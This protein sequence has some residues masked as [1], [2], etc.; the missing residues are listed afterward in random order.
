MKPQH[1]FHSP[2]VQVPVAVLH[3]L[4]FKLVCALYRVQVPLAVLDTF[5]FNHLRIRDILSEYAASRARSLFCVQVP[6]VVLD[7]FARTFAEGFV[8]L[9]GRLHLEAEV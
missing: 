5:K 1:P 6:V 4:N 9:M 7:T 2:R 8:A 3:T